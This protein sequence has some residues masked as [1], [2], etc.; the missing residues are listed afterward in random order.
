MTSEDEQSDGGDADEPVENRQFYKRHKIY[1]V[2]SIATYLDKF[3]YDI[4]NF[5][6]V[7]V[8]EVD[9]PLEKK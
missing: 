7:E 1:A 5:E 4:I 8:K 2:S 6:N 9:V 3:N